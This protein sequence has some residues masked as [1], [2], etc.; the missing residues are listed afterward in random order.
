M[1]I[2][3]PII[4]EFTGNGIEKARKEFAQLE[5]A[6]QKAQFAIK[7]AAIP[8]A[9]ALAGVGAALFD[10][11]KGAIK[12]A[13]AQDLLANNLRKTTGATDVQIA[14][15]EDWVSQQGKLLGIADDQLRPALQRLSRATGSVTKAQEL[16]TQAMDIAAATGK[17]LES[18]VSA[19]EKAYG[20]N[21]T[22]LGRLAPEYRQ[23]IKDGASFE[24]VMAK[25]GKTTGGAATDAANT[26]AGQFKRMKLALDETK[27]SVGAALLPAIEAILP[28]LT[29]FA[30]WA[31]ENPK[32]FLGI[33]GAIAGIS[34]AIIAL[35]FALAAN[36]ITLI[37]I[38]IAA[39]GAALTAAYFK[40]EG[41][42]KIVDAL[43]GAIKFYINN[44][45]I[46]LFQ[47][48]F[49][50]VKTIF[51]GIASA[52]NN[53]F[54]KLS[55]SIPNIPGL[56]GRGTKIEVPNIPML[57]NGGIVTGPTLAMIGE[58]GE[59]EA[60]IPLSRLDQMTGGGGSKVTINVNGGD[61]N[62]VVDALRK[63]Y[64]QNGP[65]PVGVSY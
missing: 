8:A 53:T 54:G 11:T 1:A 43:F 37:A 30:T 9:A 64:R 51:N 6:G 63:Y 61:P 52:W 33:A 16:A 10:A 50:I 46:P 44:V 49:S 2:S 5:T 18:V 32:V 31:S 29:K 62:A 17:P 34:A 14:A 20:G 28:Y 40:F 26:A 35:N 24:D 57:A 22:A 58:G 21:M 55:F 41:F 13:A 60:V 48:M 3:I 59:S 45:T 56:P 39:L 15:V 19:L 4:A 23:L 47:T 7:K 65:L 27:E 12:D 25:L 42:R 36:P 38:G